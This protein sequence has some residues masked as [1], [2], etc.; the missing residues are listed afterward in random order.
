MIP[1]DRRIDTATI[2]RALAPPAIATFAV[3]VLLRFPPAHYSFY[4]QCP[5]LEN[6]H[7]E[8]PG[9]RDDTRTRGLVARTTRGSV[10][11][12]CSRHPLASRR[13]R[14]RDPLL[15]SLP[16]TQTFALAADFTHRNLLRLCRGRRFYNRAQSAASLLLGEGKTAPVSSRGRRC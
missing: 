12:Q 3:T 14:L 7:L 11:L 10:P 15:L 16:A 1:R 6:L 4:P 13:C 2:A 5:I 9:C 8:C